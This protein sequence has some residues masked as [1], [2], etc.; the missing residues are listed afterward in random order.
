MFSQVFV[1]VAFMLRGEGVCQNVSKTW[2][3]LKF[4]CMLLSCCA[5]KNNQQWSNC[6]LEMGT[7]QKPGVFSEFLGMGERVCH[8]ANQNVVK[9]LVPWESIWAGLLLRLGKDI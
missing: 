3:F 9:N 2:C 6:M 5:I 8:I 1:H 4:L 7:F